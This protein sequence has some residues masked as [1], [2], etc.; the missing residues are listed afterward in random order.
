MFKKEK[1][2]NK[3]RGVQEPVPV[4]KP[5][6]EESAHI[7]YVFQRHEQ[8]Y[9]HMK[10]LGLFDEWNEAESAYFNNQ[11]DYEE[12]TLPPVSVGEEIALVETKGAEEKKV[13]PEVVL[14]PIYEEDRIKVEAMQELFENIKNKNKDKFKMANAIDTKNIYGIFYQEVYWRETKRTIK[15]PIEYDEKKDA[16]KFKK[17]DVI[18]YKDICIENTPVQQ[19]LFDE[20]ATGIDDANECI[21]IWYGNY[22]VAKLQYGKFKNWQYVE[23]GKY[24][25]CIYDELDK[26]TRKH[27]LEMSDKGIE[28]VIWKYYNEAKDEYSIICN[29][30]LLTPLD[31][32]LPYTYWKKLPFIKGDCRF[33]PAER[34]FFPKGD[35]ILINRLKKLKNIFL[36]AMGIATHVN[37]N[38]PLLTTKEV[39]QQLEDLG[40]TWMQAAILEVTSTDNA[41]I[42]RPLQVQIDYSGLERMIQRIDEIIVIITGVD[43]RSLLS[44]VQETATKTAVRQE[45][46]LKRILAGNKLVETGALERK[47]QIIIALIRQYYDQEEE[48]LIDNDLNN[49]DNK[50]PKTFKK[51]K[52]IAVKDKKYEWYKKVKPIAFSALLPIIEAGLPPAL[53]DMVFDIESEKLE[54]LLNP[55]TAEIPQAEDQEQMQG[56]GMPQPQENQEEEEMLELIADLD[57]I[58]QLKKFKVLPTE[59]KTLFLK[60]LKD[61]EEWDLEKEE[62][63]GYKG[64]L[65]IKTELFNVEF[66]IKVESR[67]DASYSELFKQ[68]QADN[69]AG[70]YMGNPVVD[71]AELA[72]WHLESKKVPTDKLIKNQEQQAQEQQMMMQQQAQQQGGGQA[73]QPPAQMQ[74]P[75]AEQAM[76]G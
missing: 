9:S 63:E 62:K 53:V 31:N 76:T 20:T 58:K 21:K 10:N 73:P 67:G 50:K 44:T 74:P 64:E 65:E 26:D 47:A 68:E 40:L 69:V 41:Q 75:M 56:E 71:Q 39:R 28:V 22:D 72:K 16:Y 70:L 54:E 15:I 5:S 66:E 42:T 13:L 59:I 3:I 57:E 38:A 46:S 61:N 51:P 43:T 27:L 1:K 8:M 35:V 2:L 32:P 30:V 48:Y 49:D 34:Q 52:S 14:K 4:Y 55:Q 37:A 36:N 33:M 29:G 24:T 18:D 45:T 19:M 6:K 17:Y 11:L 60:L 12:D 7:T 23:K 25:A